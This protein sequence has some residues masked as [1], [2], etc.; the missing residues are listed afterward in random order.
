MSQKGDIFTRFMLVITILGSHW[1]IF[2]ESKSKG[3]ANE[4]E[5]NKLIK[6]VEKLQKNQGDYVGNVPQN[7]TFCTFEAS[8]YKKIGNPGT[9][10]LKLKNLTCPKAQK[11]GY[12]GFQVPG[13]PSLIL[14][15]E[16]CTI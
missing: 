2:I 9:R 5:I 4:S 11:P 13:F 8:N 16:T 7:S 15:I 12:P 6:N 14:G 3:A 10:V 1:L